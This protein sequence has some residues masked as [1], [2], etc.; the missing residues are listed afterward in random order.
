MFKLDHVHLNVKNLDR[1]I[2]FYEELLG[3]K[4]QHRYKE[5][6]ADFQTNDGTYLGL[7]NPK[8]DDKEHTHMLGTNVTPVFRTGNIKEEHEMI[9]RLSPKTITGI[10][11]INF[12][13]PYDFFMFEDTE[14]NIWEVA[15]YR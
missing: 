11:H 8:D 5:R 7:Y 1:A 14:G 3:M 4:V 12:I 13:H 10:Q 6:W 15:E 2:K 9:R